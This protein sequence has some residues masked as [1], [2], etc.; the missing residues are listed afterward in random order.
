MIDTALIRRFMDHRIRRFRAEDDLRAMKNEEKDMARQINSMLA[1]ESAGKV[2]I[3]G[4]TVYPMRV[5]RASTVGGC[6]P[7]LIDGFKN[8]GMD[9][10]VSQTINAQTLTGFVNE[11]DPDRMMSAEELAEKLPDEIRE[12][13]NLYEDLMVGVR[14]SG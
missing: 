5:M 7:M 6:M 10:I 13:I 4:H 11:Y 12:F 14:K 3:D 1:S 8:L 2:N 9:S